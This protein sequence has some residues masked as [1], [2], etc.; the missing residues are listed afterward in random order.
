MPVNITEIE[1]HLP[2]APKT[3]PAPAEPAP[4]NNRT[5]EARGRAILAASKWPA[6]SEG[7]RNNAAF[8]HACYLL[9]DFDL[10]EADAWEILDTWNRINVKPLDEAEL[11]DVLNSA[12]K[13]GKHPPGC[14]LTERPKQKTPGTERDGEPNVCRPVFVWMKDIQSKPVQWLWQDRI[15]SAMLSLL[16]GLEGSGKTFTALDLAARVTTGRPLPGGDVA[17][18]VPPIGNVVFLT[19]EDHLEFTI[20]P[21]LDAME[22]DPARIAA[23]QGVKYPEGDIDLFDIMR[24]LPA[25]ESLIQEA[26]PVQLVVVDPLTA[27]LGATDQHRNG[28]VRMALARFNSLAEKYNCAVIGI[29]HLSKDTNRQAIH[30]TLGSVAFT[31]AARTVWLVSADRENPDRRLFVPVKNNLAPLAKSLAF[32]IDGMAVVWEDGDFEYEADDVLAAGKEEPGAL[33]DAGQWLL[34]VLADGRIRSGDIFTMAAKEKISE[35]TLRRA[36][37]KIGVEAVHDGIGT[38]SFWYWQKP[39]AAKDAPK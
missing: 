27:Y 19:S 14:K 11:R 35:K 25:L 18:N 31:A 34:E 16:V 30:R 8:H 37:A 15:P 23:L 10:S 1:C 4:T 24:H 26:A 3:I 6:A 38:A 17:Y 20:R 13:Y 28:E 9:K 32:R 21:R 12:K 39:K 29:S 22:A 2:S 7:E 36:K 33:A 5:L